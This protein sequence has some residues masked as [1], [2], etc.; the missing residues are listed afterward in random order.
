MSLQQH[1][2]HSCCRGSLAQLSSELLELIFAYLDLKS[3]GSV[4]QTCRTLNSQRWPVVD[5][6]HIR[7]CRIP[8]PALHYVLARRRPRVLLLSG[9]AGCPKSASV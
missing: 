9:L 6:Q 1:K 8:L 3:L 4:A 2:E 5:A 7:I